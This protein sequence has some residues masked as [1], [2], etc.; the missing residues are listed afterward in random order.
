MYIINKHGILHSIPDN[1]TV[2]KGS[3]LATPHE[4]EQFET[5]GEQNIA[6][7]P[8]PVTKKTKLEDK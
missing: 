8:A 3:R 4:V 7:M 5:T 2:P 6:K 1:W